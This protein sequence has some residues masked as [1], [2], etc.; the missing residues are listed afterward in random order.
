M[1][2]T[3]FRNA[4]LIVVII[5]LGASYFL[6]KRAEEE[7]ATIDRAEA[8]LIQL[9]RERNNRE[10]LSA[11]LANLDKLTVDE[12]DTTRLDILRH[13]NL[14]TKDYDF[15]LQSKQAQQ[16]GGT[17]LYA[18]NFSVSTRLPY[19]KA[20]QL[21]DFLHANKKVVLSR[22]ALREVTETHIYGDQVDIEINGS[23]YGLEKR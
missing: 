10:A 3:T 11:Q 22:Y 4:W 14:E 15:Y 12:R 2:R 18:R 9:K 19:A 5:L 20:L 21:A 17:T 16:I 1:K 13:L 7:F 8:V 23:L 6:F